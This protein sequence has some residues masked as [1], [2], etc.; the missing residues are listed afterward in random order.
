[1]A[2]NTGIGDT[3]EIL[4][5]EGVGILIHKSNEDGLRRSAAELVAPA[6]DPS[7]PERCR[8]VAERE[9][10]RALGVRRHAVYRNLMD[11]GDDGDERRES[12][13]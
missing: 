7:T 3:A 12:P 1:M 11:L 10:D 8:G 9:Y 4:E 2:A 5:H 13:S 6:A